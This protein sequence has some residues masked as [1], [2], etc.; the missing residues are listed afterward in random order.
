MNLL[1]TELKLIIIN[2]KKKQNIMLI[3]GVINI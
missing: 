3:K 1:L 2:Y